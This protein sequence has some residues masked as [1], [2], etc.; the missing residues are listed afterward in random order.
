M[1]SATPRIFW[2]KRQYMGLISSRSSTCVQGQKVH[3]HGQDPQLPQLAVEVEVHARVQG[4]VGAADQDHE[5]AVGR[6]GGQD[7]PAPGAE[8]S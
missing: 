6:Q 7:L 5:P 8:A 2:P 3:G 1:C 4:V